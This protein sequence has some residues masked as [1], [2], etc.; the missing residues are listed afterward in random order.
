MTPRH[1]RR[2]RR[3]K[4]KTFGAQLLGI[5]ATYRRLQPKPRSVLVASCA[6]ILV[7]GTIGIVVGTQSGADTPKPSAAQTGPGYDKPSTEPTATIAEATP[8]AT[9]TP[10]KDRKRARDLRGW[11]KEEKMTPSDLSVLGV[12][13]PE[14]ML[15]VYSLKNVAVRGST[16][17]LT[18][19]LY[20]KGDAERVLRRLQSG[21]PRLRPRLGEGGQGHRAGRRRARLV[22]RR[23]R[24]RHRRLHWIHGLPVGLGLG[25]DRSR[26]PCWPR[27]WTASARASAV[28]GKS[29]RLPVPCSASSPARQAGRHWS[30]CSM[31][32][33][34][35]EGVPLIVIQRQLGR[36]KVRH[37]L[38]L[39]ARHRHRR[40]HRYGPRPPRTDA[41]R[42]R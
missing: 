20:A 9:E 7:A 11:F 31:T 23:G 40:S 41:S 32:Q 14:S 29:A 21:H 13:A 8:T 18:T 12:D 4:P 42:Q 25:G 22:V 6:L 36:S 28:D 30:I 38:D 2:S 3:V 16:V 24:R 33:P 27:C 5:V 1:R 19:D 10:A 34:G 15:R 35:A 39:P 17:A 37:H 26:L